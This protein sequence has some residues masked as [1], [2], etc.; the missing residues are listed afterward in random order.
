MK[1]EQE[2]AAVYSRDQAEG[3]IPNGTRVKKVA[4]DVGDAHPIG[5]LATVLGSMGPVPDSSA[6][7]GPRRPGPRYGYFV[8]FDGEGERAI[9]I[10]DFKIEAP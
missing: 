8:R 5:A 10:A 2:G 1:F 6:L 9:F 4:G 3:A 7:P